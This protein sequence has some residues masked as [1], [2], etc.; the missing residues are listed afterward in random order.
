MVSFFGPPDAVLLV[1][2]FRIPVLDQHKVAS[3]VQIGMYGDAF[4][5][6]SRAGV[7]QAIF[8]PSLHAS[9]D[10]GLTLSSTRTKTPILYSLHS[11]SRLREPARCRSHP[12]TA[13]LSAT[14]L[15]FDSFKTPTNNA[16]T[17]AERAMN[18]N[19]AS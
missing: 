5:A 11:F 13:T 19:P 14:A 10:S 1:L 17:P 18:V 16:D 15:T 3:I 12:L 6:F 4:T 2:L 7:R 9:I 8:Q